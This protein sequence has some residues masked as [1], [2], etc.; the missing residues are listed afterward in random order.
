MGSPRNENGHDDNEEPQHEVTIARP[1][2][3]SKYEV[4]F[5]EW[6][7]CVDHGDCQRDISASGWGRARRPVINVSWN[8]AKRYVAWLSRITGKEYRLLSEAEWEYSA[9]ADSTTAYAWGD[10]V[11]KDNKVMANCYECGSQWDGRQTAAVG[12]F[13]PNAFGLH[14]MHGNVWEWVEDCWHDNYQGAPDDASAWTTGGDCG[15]RAVRGAS[16]GF[17]ADDIRSAVRFGLDTDLRNFD[18]G[19]RVARTLHAL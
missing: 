16:W 19:F 2:A 8:E 11:K 5:D 13:P 14:D 15:R 7:A 6:D 9:R 10:D 12:S 4:T 3:V 18:L 17:G 1:F